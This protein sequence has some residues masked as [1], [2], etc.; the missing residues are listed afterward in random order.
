[1]TDKK[2]LGFTLL[3]MMV[4]LGI[5]TLVIGVVAESVA[6]MQTRN[7]AEESKLDL[8]QQTRQ[9]MD[10]IIG[11]IHQSGFPSLKMFDPSTL[12][13][14]TDCS[15][16]L[17]LACGL[18]SVSSNALQFEGDVDGSGVSEVYIQE[19]PLGGPCPCTLQRGTVLKSV[20]GTPP[21]YTEVDGVMNTSVFTAYQFDGTAVS[22]PAT[23]G[24][25]N[26]SNIV[27]IG[28]TLYVR[29]SQPDPKTGQYPTVTMVASSKITNINSW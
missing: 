4:A 28:M 29:S 15:Q 2:Q 11:D 22:L 10:Q 7:T 25:G 16:D 8:T 20:G 23:H 21:Y 3:E 24:T 18:I 12:T 1:M 5:L 13:S 27:A 17:H 26:L 9:F 14:G 6:T 19:H